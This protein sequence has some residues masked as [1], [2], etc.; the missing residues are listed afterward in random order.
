MHRS[1]WGQKPGQER[2]LA[3]RMSRAGWERALGLAIPTA[4]EPAI[5]RTPDEWGRRFRE[6]AV[7]LQ[8]DTERS[9]RGEA[10]PCSSIQVGLGRA[11]IV[12]YVE[13]WV[14]EI[15]DLTPRVARMRA[16]LLA[17]KGSRARR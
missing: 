12:E 5:F 16:D 11:V 1:R 2:I 7:H 13:D 14:R 15:A 3:V 4:F 10:L 9:L 8:W 6:A 17:G